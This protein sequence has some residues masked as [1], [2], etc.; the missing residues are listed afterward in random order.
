[1]AKLAP[2]RGMRDFPPAEMARRKEVV[3]KVESVFAS[4][5]YAPFDTP[6]LESIELLRA[7]CGS[8]VEKQ[9]FETGKLGLRFDLTVPLARFVASNPSLPKPFKRYAIGPVW[10][11]EEPQKGRFREFLQADIDIAGGARVECDAELL[12]C[13]D[14]ALRGLGFREFEILVNNRKVLD[15]IAGKIGIENVSQVFRSVD[16]LQKIGEE[17]VIGEMMGK[18]IE[19]KK[20]K[21]LLE[22][23]SFEGKNEKI[24]EMLEKNYACE[25][26]EELKRLLELC[27]AYG[28]GNVKIKLSLARGLD[29]Y[30]G[31]VFE[32]YAGG[33]VG[34]IGGGGRYDRMIDELG[35]VPTPMTGISLGIERIMELIGGE[36]AEARPSVFVACVKSEFYPYAIS[37]ARE[38]RNSGVTTQTDLMGRNLRKQF[39]YANS[40]GISFVAVVGEK[41]KKGGKLNLRDMASGKESLVSV[42][43]AVKKINNAGGQS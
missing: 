31:P 26:V 16:K 9:I 24:L 1:M 29:Y 40:L 32:I 21:N 27:G 43:E 22:A 34:S 8:D 20:A 13:S 19:E 42:A 28:M 2:P 6:A 33:G 15:E 25:G 11:R 23:I 5:G 17:G 4:F 39:E 41:E 14:A 37:V 12:A 7:K 35:G 38:L 30:T 18:G 3:A 10:R 36:K